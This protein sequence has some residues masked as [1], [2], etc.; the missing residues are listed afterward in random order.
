[1]QREFNIVQSESE[2][3]FQE[4]VMNETHEDD[5]A[6]KKNERNVIVKVTELIGIVC[7]DLI[8]ELK[9]WT[10]TSGGPCAK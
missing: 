9:T 8:S 6:K 1:M 5:T 4:N 7:A 10:R 3:T 2:L